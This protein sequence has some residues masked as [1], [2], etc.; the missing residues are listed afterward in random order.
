MRSTTLLCTVLATVAALVDGHL[1]FFDPSS[2]RL[3]AGD[4]IVR[5]ARRDTLLATIEHSGYDELCTKAL[6]MASTS[7]FLPFTATALESIRTLMAKHNNG[8]VPDLRNAIRIDVHGS[9]CHALT[10]SRSFRD[11]FA[12]I[13]C[14]AR[15]ARLVSSACSDDRRESDAGVGCGDSFAVHGW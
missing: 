9:S 14:S 15:G 13:G 6:Q 5:D 10:P 3:S 1:A 11:P 4:A 12:E 2:S 8:T 7:P